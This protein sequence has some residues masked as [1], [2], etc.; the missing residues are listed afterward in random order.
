MTT[1]TGLPLSSTVVRRLPA[2]PTALLVRVAAVVAITA[3]VLVSV[4]EG[5]GSPAWWALPVLF[6]AVAVSE[7]AV[8]HLSFGRQRWTFSCTEGALGAAWVC[9]TGSWSVAAVALGVLLAQVL[10]HQP[11]LKLEYTV[12][13][14]AVSTAAGSATA[15]ALGGGLPGA[16]AGMGV[17]F[18]IN[19]GLVALVVATT[20]RRSLI[21]LLWAGAPL[22][23]V[24]TAG[25]TSIGLLAAWLALNAPL[26]LLGL[27]VPLV[28]LWSSYDQ[29]TH[30]AAEARLFAELARGQERATG[31]SI[32]SS[33]QV[34]ITAA[35]RLF[36]GADV[37]LLLLAS[38][39]PVRFVGNELAVPERR[40]VDAAA[41]DEPWVVRAL[42]A[43]TVLTGS[44]DGRP[45]CSAVL[46]DPSDPVA[47]LVARRP[48][49]SPGFG[50]REARLAEVL[51]GQAASWL[52]VAD[53]VAR[54]DEALGRI[55]AV[56]DSARALSDLGAHTIP[57]LVV[58]R[59]SAT[60][61]ARLAEAPEGRD[62]V[63]DIVDELHT[64]ERAVASLLGAIALAAETDFDP[65]AVAA[66][67][68]SAPTGTR[69]GADW[70]TTG[71]LEPR[72]VRP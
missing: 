65:A 11:R 70:T 2:V 71:R 15:M 57:S 28:L 21:G 64:V 22:S 53:L 59:E 41:F 39:G 14:F 66:T 25:N 49:G 31:R 37:E 72:Q 52:S 48:A 61:L 7:V 35:A 34:V 9:A 8:V 62:P 24:H 13:Q 45:Y 38:D 43:R 51:A 36:G 50:R 40:R 19:H 3:A 18:L 6:A 23:A 44:V 68:V 33:V 1:S 47:V 46:G 67:A 20:T 54:H 26:G 4:G 10:R 60:R 27:I 69:P 32:D 58:L 29:Q 16:C 42:Q 30:G 5:W 56:G 12:A 17:F 63:S 55:A